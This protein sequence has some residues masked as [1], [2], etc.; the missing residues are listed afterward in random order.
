MAVT[1]STAAER[2]RISHARKTGWRRDEL[3]GLAAA[4]LIL[5]FGLFQVYRAKSA[6]LAGID[7]GLASKQLLDLNALTAREEL[8]PALSSIADPHARDEAARQIYYVAGGLKNVGALARIHGLFTGEQFRQLKPVFV[9]RRPAQ[10]QSAFY[11]WS[12]LFFAAFLAVHLFWS[13]RGF[14]GDQFLLPAVMLLTGAGLI[15]MIAL[16]DPV[17]DNLLFVD[18]AQGVAVGCLLLAALRDR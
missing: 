12:A 13:L 3:I 8:L 11:P 1:R 14:R 10:F 7:H 16:R 2:P 5:A 4:T 15:L 6:D 17:R 9:V 18:F